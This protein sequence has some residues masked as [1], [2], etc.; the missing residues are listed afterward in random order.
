MPVQ[1]NIKALPLTK[2]AQRCARETRLFFQGQSND[3]GYCFELFR[4][5]FEDGDQEAWSRIYDQ[6]RPLVTGWVKQ[7]TAFC[8]SDEEAQYFV[9]RAFEKMWGAM[10]P[11]KFSRFSDL[12][13]LLRYMQTCVHSVVVDHVRAVRQ[14]VLVLL[15]EGLAD[16]D[17]I[18]KGVFVESLALAQVYRQEVWREISV[19]LHN[20]EE[21]LVVYCTFILALKPRKIHARYPERFPDVSDVYRVKENVLSRLRRDV[22]LRKFLN[23]DA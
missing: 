20:E 22:E 17:M 19:R 15:I 1:T 7:H 8:A 6:Y 11:A 16:E 14:S 10:T 18:G 21:R 9:N 5:A 4:L 3:T 2:L 12:K 13:F 23:D